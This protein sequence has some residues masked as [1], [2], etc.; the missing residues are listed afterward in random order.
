MSTYTELQETLNAI[1]QD[2]NTNLKSSNLRKN[3]KCL[4]VEGQL[5]EGSGT[6][7]SDAT[8]YPENI[9]NGYTAYAR[10]DK[11]T[12]T[13]VPLDT[14]DATAENSDIL[15]GK[16]AY[17]DGVKIEG[18]MLDHNNVTI[19][20]LT[21]SQT[22]N[23]G[24]YNQIRVNAVDSSIDENIIPANIMRGV[25]ILG[26]L[27]DAVI[28]ATDATA[29][30]EDVLNGKTAYLR[31]GITTGSMPNNGNTSFN[32]RTTRQSI[33]AG[34]YNGNG[35]INAVTSSIDSNI[36]ASNIKAGVTIL[37]V[38]GALDLLDTFDATAN[39]STILYGTTA[40][41]KGAKVVGT[42]VL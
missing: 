35:Y 8:A 24:H 20:P 37:G 4:G 9:L 42:M 19:T 1:L 33:P 23:E 21:T 15:L 22:F 14:S 17:V 38:T 41:V 36:K 3:V 7:T 10:G 40:Y 5:V 32:P 11:I 30:A 39:A 25:T 34:Y 6:D 18:T 26:V 27:G 12:G 2:K 31:N 16:T 29:V 28:E 13:Y